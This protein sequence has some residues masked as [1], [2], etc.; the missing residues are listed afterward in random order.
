MEDIRTKGCHQIAKLVLRPP[1]K[2]EGKR[3]QRI[4][5]SRSR[6]EWMPYGLIVFVGVRSV[7]ALT[8]Q[9]PVG[10]G[11]EEYVYLVSSP[12]QFFRKIL[13]EDRITSKVIRREMGGYH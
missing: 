12:D 7:V 6:R 4:K 8:S 1:P 13:N 9:K 10:S 3:K 5:R 11:I 2:P